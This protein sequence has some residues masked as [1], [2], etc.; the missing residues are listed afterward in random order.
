MP[1]R[2]SF[3]RSRGH[4]KSIKSGFGSGKLPD[5]NF[6]VNFMSCRRLFG[7]VS[8]S[9]LGDLCGEASSVRIAIG[10]FAQASNVVEEPDGYMI[11]LVTTALR[12]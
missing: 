4:P 8:G 9:F 7:G 5:V 12:E 11:K 2:V 10:P 1:F 6:G 3:L